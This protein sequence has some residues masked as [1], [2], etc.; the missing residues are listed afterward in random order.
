MLPL[1][2]NQ[3][4]ILYLVSTPI[5]NLE[6][7]TLRA[8]KILQTVD[9]IAAEDTRHTKPLLVHFGISRPLT[10]YHDYNKEKK[11]AAL[12]ADLNAGKKIALVSDAG[13]PGISDPGYHLIQEALKQN[14]PVIPIPGACAIT[15]GLA[16]SGLSTDRFI[17]EGFLPHKS[18]ARRN[19]LTFFKGEERT[20]I[21]YES[22]YRIRSC[23]E[24]ILEV[25]GDIPCVIGRELTKKFEEFIRGPVS[26]ILSQLNK[27]LVRGELVL[28]ISQKS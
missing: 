28:M 27:T 10:S 5:G 4:G 13:T 22:P 15:C 1:P 14:I 8:I 20:I 19:R 17:F 23:L 9:L 2:E 21:F 7:M 12:I 3:N 24:D 26:L 18:G 25:L 11:V 6:D 16:A